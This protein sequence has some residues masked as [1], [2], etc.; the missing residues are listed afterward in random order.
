VVVAVAVCVCVGPV[1]VYVTPFCTVTVVEVVAVLELVLDE[2]ELVVVDKVD[3]EVLVDEPVVAV[4]FQAL[5]IDL[6][7]EA[8]VTYR[9]CLHCVHISRCA[10]IGGRRGSRKHGA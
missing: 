6:P 2:V 5:A 8:Q 4:D 10:S 1:R 7:G 3:E 9:G